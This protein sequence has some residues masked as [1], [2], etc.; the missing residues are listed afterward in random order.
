MCCECVFVLCGKQNQTKA[1]KKPQKTK[2]YKKS[3]PNK[4]KTK[5]KTPTVFNIFFFYPFHSQEQLT[6]ASQEREA[7]TKLYLKN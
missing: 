2:H 4:N 1:K 7:Y 6:N 3:K 5:M